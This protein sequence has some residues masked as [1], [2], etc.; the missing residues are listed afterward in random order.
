MAHSDAVAV[1]Y[2]EKRFV[3]GLRVRDLAGS[4]AGYGFGRIVRVDMTKTGF[5]IYLV[6]PNDALFRMILRP[7][8]GWRVVC[9]RKMNIRCAHGWENGLRTTPPVPLTPD[10]LTFDVDCPDAGEGDW[11]T[12][13]S[14]IFMVEV[15]ATTGS[16]IIDMFEDKM[17][18]LLRLRRWDNETIFDLC[19]SNCQVGV[20]ARLRKHEYNKPFGRGWTN[21]MAYWNWNNPASFHPGK[22]RVQVAQKPV[23]TLPPPNVTA[24]ITEA[25]QHLKGIMHF[26]LNDPEQKEFEVGGLQGVSY[27]KEVD[28]HDT[29]KLMMIE[30]TLARLAARIEPY[31][32]SLQV[33]RS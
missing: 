31:G 15:T 18:S 23:T 1:I 16:C 21:L 22:H 28:E 30:W 11:D 32:G 26:G 4:L 6:H 29:E 33:F 9:G 19:E 17:T 27:W 25:E 24:A 13:K 2:I 3:D 20:M 7:R 14:K 12:W 5:F 8:G 10:V